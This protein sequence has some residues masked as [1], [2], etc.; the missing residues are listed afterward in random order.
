MPINI[1]F[2]SNAELK[3]QGFPI[4]KKFNNIETIVDNVKSLR[5]V[6]VYGSEQVAVSNDFQ[7]TFFPKNSYKI[8]D[9]DK[10]IITDKDQQ[11]TSLTDEITQLTFANDK[12]NNENI[13]L[14][15]QKAL[16][17]REIEDLKAQNIDKDNQIKALKAQLKVDIN[18]NLGKGAEN[19]QSEPKKDQVKK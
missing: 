4:G 14:V 17:E 12:L 16:C 9:N 13:E 15:Q 10:L 3:A 18:V 19:Q 8:L 1:Q 6:A 5:T 11:I 7:L 2:L